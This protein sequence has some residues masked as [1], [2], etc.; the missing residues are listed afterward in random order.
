MTEETHRR[1]CIL[2]G[3]VMLA[4]DINTRVNAQVTMQLAARA[5][6]AI[7]PLIAITATVSESLAAISVVGVVS[8]GVRLRDAMLSLLTNDMD[9]YRAASQGNIDAMTQRA[10]SCDEDDRIIRLLAPR[11]LQ[12]LYAPEG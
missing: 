2:L 5:F 10:A 1:T 4:Q 6:T 3:Q 12:Q 8:E 11:V 9:A 7:P